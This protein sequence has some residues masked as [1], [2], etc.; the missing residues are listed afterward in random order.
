MV[1]NLKEKL[2]SI[3]A[4]IVET[5]EKNGTSKTKIV[6]EYIQVEK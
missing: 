5:L 1:A 4:Q 3:Q 6:I 2:I